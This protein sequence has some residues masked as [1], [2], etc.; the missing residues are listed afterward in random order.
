MN[1]APR[2]PLV[3]QVAFGLL[4]LLALLVGAAALRFALP[5]QPLAPP[6]P[7]LTVQ[8]ELLVIH[9]VSAGLALMLGP[10]QFA[11]G[12]RARRPRLHRCIGYGYAACLLVGGLSALPLAAQAMGGP[13]AQL[14]FGLLGLGWLGTT[15]VALV[16]VRA[17]RIA[18]H[19]R[20]MVRSFALTAAGISLRLQLGVAGG[21]GVP[22][23]VIY[24]ALAW[25][26]WVPNVLAAELW[27]WP[28]AQPADPEPGWEPTR[29]GVD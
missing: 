23:E 1:T 28:K 11:A 4:V 8:R 26:C 21:F 25:T 14:G 2:S 22:V 9:A 29:L 16:H 17:G 5:G 27:L 15:A 10:W 19:R 7:N 18:A 24:T 6:L 3:R 13:L 20:W 12:L